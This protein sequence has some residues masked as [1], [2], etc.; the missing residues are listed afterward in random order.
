MEESQLSAECYIRWHRSKYA[1]V[2]QQQSQDWVCSMWTRLNPFH[3]FCFKISHRS[4]ILLSH[5]CSS[6][7]VKT[8]LILTQYSSISFLLRLTILKRK[9]LIVRKEAYNRST[10]WANVWIPACDSR[11]SNAQYAASQSVT[12]NNHHTSQ[13][14]KRSE[15]RNKKNR[16]NKTSRV[17]C[18]T[19]SFPLL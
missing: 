8:N 17:S 6:D 10:A 11:Q 4:N 15:W 9:Y 19:S 5:H 12:S 1:A 13:E 18:C 7:Q 14:Y 16:I 2:Y 3:S